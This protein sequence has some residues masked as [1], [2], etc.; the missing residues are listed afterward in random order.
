[1]SLLR[2]QETLTPN[3]PEIIPEDIHTFI[4][5][6]PFFKRFTKY[7]KR[8]FL[9]W[10]TRQTTLETNSIPDNTGSILWI[11]ISSPSL[12]DTLMDLAGRTLLKNKVVSLFTDPFTVQLYQADPY[13]KMATS[14]IQDL[15]NQ[16]FDHILIDSYGTKGILTKLKIGRTTTFSGMYGFFDGPEVNKIL[17]SYFRINQLIDTPISENRI[18]QQAS[19]HIYPGKQEVTKIASMKLPDHFI[20]IAIGGEWGHRI[21]SHWENVI[22]ELPKSLSIVL[23]GSHNG[24]K[25]AQQ[26]VSICKKHSIYNF[27]GELSIME[28]TAL[29]SKSQLLICADGGLMHIAH[30]VQVPTLAL[31]ATVNPKHFTTATNK[32]TSL[33]DEYQ[34]SNISYLKVTSEI[35]QLLTEQR[36]NL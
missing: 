22:Q 5:N 14:D 10:I 27:A 32:V 34:V 30:G 2:F 13:F 9:L 19:T 17:F 36:I 15:T 11:N 26:I 23:I 8:H 35:K 4:Q 3:F 24:V 28:T 16:S 33:F 20:A 12:G 18:N 21:Y 1:M 6:T 25:H 31:F 29:I 7:L